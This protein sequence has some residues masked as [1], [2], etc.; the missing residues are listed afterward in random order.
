MKDLMSLSCSLNLFSAS[1]KASSLTCDRRRDGARWIRT[2]ANRTERA[3]RR[4]G[5][6]VQTYLRRDPRQVLE[7]AADPVGLLDD[8]VHAQLGDL[9]DERVLVAFSVL[10]HCGQQGESRSQGARRQQAEAAMRLGGIFFLPRSFLRLYSLML[11][12][13]SLT[14]SSA[15][16][17]SGRSW[18]FSG[19]A[20]SSSIS[21]SG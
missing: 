5:G 20:P 21:S 7:V 10:H 8:G 15:S 4:C 1:S 11:T 13:I 18:W 6:G 16:V 12:L 3:P 14:A 9:V 17:S 2:E 19:V